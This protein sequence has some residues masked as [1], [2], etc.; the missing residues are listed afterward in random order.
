MKG[1][2]WECQIGEKVY[3]PYS[4]DEARKLLDSGAIAA[5]TSVRRNGAR[6]MTAAA[7]FGTPRGPVQRQDAVPVGDAH[8]TDA[9]GRS[10]VAGVVAKLKHGAR[11]AGFGFAGL[12]AL[13][14]VGG[15]AVNGMEAW[16]DRRERDAQRQEALQEFED[17][18]AAY[19]S[20]RQET[21]MALG[22]ALRGLRYYLGEGPVARRVR[23]GGEGHVRVVSSAVEAYR[24]AEADTAGARVLSDVRRRERAYREIEEEG[25]D[26]E[27]REFAIGERFDTDM[28][29]RAYYEAG[30][31]N[32]Y[33]TVVLVADPDELGRRPYGSVRSL[34]VEYKGEQEY[35]V[36]R[37]TATGV[38]ESKK[39][40][41]TYVLKAD[42]NDY[43]RRLRGAEEALYAAEAEA[44]GR[45]RE[46]V[47][48]LDRA[49]AE[50]LRVV[51]DAAVAFGASGR[52][53][54]E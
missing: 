9:P 47:E 42:G 20:G 13:V 35:G 39:Y 41:E 31:M 17:A 15:L 11:M 48:E 24:Q 2:E 3:G 6:W 32:S 40:Y 22:D 4:T 45:R 27:E 43:Y 52:G 23:G 14:T 46:A 26:L 38:Y 51:D 44:E 54:V 30:D 53:G 37:R 25:R 28:T 7:A 5:D 1:D 19:D 16:D 21:Q 12:V 49:R 10:A 36:E 50:V 33:R 8:D 29:G 18:L 34:M